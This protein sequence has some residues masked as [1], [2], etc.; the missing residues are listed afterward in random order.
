MKRRILKAQRRQQLNLQAGG[1]L[2]SFSQNWSLERGFKDVRSCGGGGERA[3]GHVLGGM[4][5]KEAL[6][7]MVTHG[8]GEGLR[9]GQD[10]TRQ[11]EA[12]KSVGALA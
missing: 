12:V 4:G 6:R 7:A 1:G 10:P 8:S 9:G 11:Q 3:S 5:G 2:G